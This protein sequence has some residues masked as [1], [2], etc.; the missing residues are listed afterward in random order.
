MHW[1]GGTARS[2][3]GGDRKE[4]EA[5]MSAAGLQEELEREQWLPREK[6]ER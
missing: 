1:G 3:V 4:Q 2:S 5:P 6:L